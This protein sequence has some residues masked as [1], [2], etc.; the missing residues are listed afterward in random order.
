MQSIALDVIG[1]ASDLLLKNKGNCHMWREENFIER[2][3]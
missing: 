2:K 3:R 1:Y